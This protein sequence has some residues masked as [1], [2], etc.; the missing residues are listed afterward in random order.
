MLRKRR[1]TFELSAG[2]GYLL[3]IGAMYRPGLLPWGVYTFIPAVLMCLYI[4]R[5]DNLH[6][7]K[8][9]GISWG[10]STFPIIA[11]IIEY[12]SIPDTSLGALFLCAFVCCV[13]IG[14]LCWRTLFETAWKGSLQK[15]AV[16]SKFTGGPGLYG[17]METKNISR[18]IEL[19]FIQK[20]INFCSIFGLIGVGLFA[21]DMVISGTYSAESILMELRQTYFAREVS[22]PSQ[23]ATL[24]SWGSLLSLAAAIV[25]WHHLSFLLKVLWCLAPG[26][27]FLY[28]LLSAGRQAAFQI[29]LIIIISYVARSS[30][31][32][33]VHRASSRT[34]KVGL[35]VASI[36]M[37]SYM[38]AVAHFRHDETIAE[39]KKN[40]ILS[41]FNAEFSAPID[42]SLDLLPSLARDGIAE[43]I[44]YFSSPPTIFMSF[45][46]LERIGPYYGKFTVP[47]V[48]RRFEI[49]GGGTVLEAMEERRSHISGTGAMIY[50]WSTSVASLMLDFTAIGAL[51]IALLVGAFSAYIHAKYLR[52]R[53]FAS[54]NLMI[55]INVL[56]VYS[57]ISPAVS[58]TNFL[59]YFIASVALFHFKGWRTIVVIDSRPGSVRKMT[60]T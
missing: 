8:W 46:D 21:S 2:L 47:Y 59:F 41:I 57:T 4:G 42:K 11:R 39:S 26:C 14:Y 24:L 37:I 10:I 51:V 18:I 33:Q 56:L 19:N 22:L 54:T 12:K 43:S 5:D 35:A 60:A 52:S 6:P 9:L 23:I 28:S 55:A 32:G 20:I 38:M 29:L 36:A 13:C 30:L 25:Y 44:V 58:D 3:L 48:A 7:L 31:V 49:F 50:G 16:I 27:F 53:S 17:R 15:S 40:A 34:L 45:F 1:T